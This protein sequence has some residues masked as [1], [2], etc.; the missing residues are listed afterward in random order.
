MTMILRL[1]QIK[2]TRS[3]W[4]LLVGSILMFLFGVNQFVA[5]PSHPQ[6]DP[7]GEFFVLLFSIW[8]ALTGILIVIAIWSLFSR[9]GRSYLETQEESQ[10]QADRNLV[11]WFKFVIVCYVAAFGTAI[12]LEVII[13]AMDIP[14]FPN[15]LGES[16]TNLYLLIIALCWSPIVFKHLK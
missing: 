1:L 12:P 11:W 16:Y 3:A 15:I 14:S 6:G 2:T 8:T 5:S 9:K 4:V 10:N 13:T 7:R